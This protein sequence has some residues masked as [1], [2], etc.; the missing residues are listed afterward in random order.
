MEQDQDDFFVFPNTVDTSWYDRAR[1]RDMATRLQDGG[2]YFFP[3][4]KQQQKQSRLARTFCYECPVR[5]DCLMTAL[6]ANELIDG[7]WGGT[8]P[9]ERRQLRKAA[10]RPIMF[11][12]MLQAIEDRLETIWRSE[13]AKG[14]IPPL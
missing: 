10:H 11:R 1:C 7:I 3:D 8:T 6:E 4:C 2:E 9:R 14:Y 5:V 12:S 13:N